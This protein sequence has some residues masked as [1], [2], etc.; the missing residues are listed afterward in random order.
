MTHAS[1]PTSK[2]VVTAKTLCVTAILAALVFILT[3][4]PRIP[5]P[6]GYANLGEAMIFLTILF[7]NR[8]DSALAASIGSAFSDLLGGF[9]IWIIPTFI[10]KWGMVEIIFRIIKPEAG[11][12]KFASIRTIVAFAIAVIWAVF[13][14]TVTGGFIYDSFGAALTSTPGLV[15]E[16]IINTVV[17]VVVGTVLQKAGIKA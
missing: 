14:Y 4:I 8:R 10:I 5:I 6:L 1:K 12:W 2:G 15:W 13:G 11:L 9:P 3:F 7:T 17:A 16:G